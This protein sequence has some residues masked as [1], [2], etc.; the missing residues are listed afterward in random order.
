M[1]FTTAALLAVA[2]FVAQSAAQEGECTS[3]T[4]CP[5]LCVHFDSGISYCAND[6]GHPGDVP[7]PACD[8]FDGNCFFDN[9]G[10]CQQWTFV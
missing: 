1:R 3:P 10:T 4:G 2:A 9:T 7:C 8:G 5:G 6:F